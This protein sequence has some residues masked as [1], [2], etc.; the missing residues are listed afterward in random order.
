VLGFRVPTELGDLGHHLWHHL[1]VPILKF[2]GRAVLRPARTHR[3]LFVP[4]MFSFGK[5][6]LSAPF[7]T[8]L[9][10]LPETLKIGSAVIIAT[11]IDSF[12]GAVSYFR[13]VCHDVSARINSKLLCTELSTTKHLLAGAF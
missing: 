13:S 2:Q 5:A 7:E 9:H 8:F 4:H 10:F 6:T 3:K 1:I 11:V 12:D